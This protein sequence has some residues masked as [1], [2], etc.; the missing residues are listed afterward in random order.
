MVGS[1]AQSLGIAA[2]VVTLASSSLLSAAQIQAQRN[3]AQFQLNEAVGVDA[4]SAA[5]TNQR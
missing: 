2:T 4:G 3:A 1:S 5:A